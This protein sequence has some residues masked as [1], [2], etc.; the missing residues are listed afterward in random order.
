VTT[1]APL[2]SCQICGGP[3]RCAMASADAVPSP[4]WCESM[5]IGAEVC[6]GTD[7]RDAI[8]R[9]FAD[10]RVSYIHLHN[11]KRGCFSCLVERAP[12]PAAPS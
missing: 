6:A 7:V 8:E 4:C 5:S 12:A 11:A 9:P 2:S 3:N 10:A 1:T